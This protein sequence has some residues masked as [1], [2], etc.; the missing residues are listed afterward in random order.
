M[1]KGTLNGR[2]NLTALSFT[3]GG[4]LSGG[5]PA[6][7]PRGVVN[8]FKRGRFIILEESESYDLITQP[9]KQRAT[10]GLREYM[11]YFVW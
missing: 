8:S 9:G 4:L 7:L 5:I 2:C 1:A 11:Q 10:K 6:P 3:G